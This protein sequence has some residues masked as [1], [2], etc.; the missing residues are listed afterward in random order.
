MQVERKTKFI[1][2]FAG[3]QPIL[4]KN[5]VFWWFLER[6]SH[7]FS[8]ILQINLRSRTDIKQMMRTLTFNAEIKKVPDIDGAYIEVPFDIKKQFGKGRLKVH[9]AFNGEPY[10]GS[11]VNMGI[12][13][14][15]GSICYILG[16]RKD[17]RAK[18]GKQP[19]DMIE[20]KVEII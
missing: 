4:S 10:N 2:I 6:I 7:F 15:D 1:L 13:N 20:V 3:T 19:G 16:I 5:S 12:R 8:F 14:A 18:I 17:I 9:A 11:I